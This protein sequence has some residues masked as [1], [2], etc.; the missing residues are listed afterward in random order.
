MVDVAVAKKRYEHGTRAR[1]SLGKCRCERCREAN[2]TYANNLARR[3]RGP[4]E[5]RFV[6]HPPVTKSQR[7][8]RHGYYIVRERSTGTIVLRTPSKSD[9]L[10]RRNDLNDAKR[11]PA[12]EQHVDARHVRQIIA[13]LEHAGLN[14]HTIARHAHV[15]K[16][17]IRKIKAGTQ[18]RV[19]RA[20]ATAITAMHDQL[21][22]WRR[23]QQ[24]ANGRTQL[25]AALQSMS[26]AEFADRLARFGI[27]S[28]PLVGIAL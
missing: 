28:D 26:A 21:L 18:S 16:W 9:A 25:A 2:R 7:S 8:T 1:Y 15:C 20:T 19:R 12:P 4:F 13:E 24:P 10:Q 6:A 27:R 22:A 11:P 17:T 14:P 3:R 23:A 5:L